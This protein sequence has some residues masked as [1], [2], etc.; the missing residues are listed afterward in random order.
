[1]ADSQLKKR[2]AVAASIAVLMAAGFTAFRLATRQNTPTSD[3]L[4][5]Q[6]ILHSLPLGDIDTSRAPVFYR[7][8]IAR[9]DHP[10]PLCVAL[11]DFL[12]GPVPASSTFTT[13]LDQADVEEFSDEYQAA[14]Y[15]AFQEALSIVE[16]G[17]EALAAYA[18]AI[19]LSPND[20][21]S[22][23]RVAVYDH[24]EPGLRSARWLSQHDPENALGLYLEATYVVEMNP[25]AAIALIRQAN[26]RP[27]LR[28]Y[29]DP[30]PTHVQGT[31]PDA[32]DEIGVRH[33]RVT[34]TALRHLMNV[35]NSIVE[36]TNPLS[37]RIESVLDRLHE[38]GNDV[39]HPDAHAAIAAHHASCHQL[40][41]NQSGSLRLTVIGF[42]RY[43][44]SFEL[45]QARF[46]PGTPHYDAALLKH[47][48][49]EQFRRLMREHRGRDHERIAIDVEAIF[50]GLSDP[51]LDKVNQLREIQSE[52]RAP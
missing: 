34:L 31:Y 44:R 2:I 42:L 6:A 29:D 24:G 47:K 36:I 28:V 16:G 35:Q 37:D 32:Y 7:Q 52:A 26:D 21:V 49:M 51:V 43:K 38:I 23:F 19:R 40:I 18:T 41:F 9:S 8:A 22:H 46:E 5:V 11:G 20:P 14:F 30:L 45:A 10:G 13:A 50:S 48:E 4:W 27:A 33:H 1:M 15:S 12:R 25:R 17:D 39:T 3:E